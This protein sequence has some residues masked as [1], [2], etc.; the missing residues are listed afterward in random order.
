MYNKCCQSGWGGEWLGDGKSACK[1]TCYTGKHF[2]VNDLPVKSI[3]WLYK[4]YTGKKKSLRDRQI[5]TEKSV[6]KCTCYTGKHFPG[7]DPP[8]ETRPQ[9][10][11]HIYGQKNAYVAGRYFARKTSISACKCTCY[12]GKHIPG[13]YLPVKNMSPGNTKHIQANIL[14][15]WQ[16]DTLPDIQTN[17]SVLVRL[18]RANNSPEIYLPVN[19]V[20]RLLKAS[21]DTNISY[22]PD[23]QRLCP[24]DRQICLY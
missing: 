8:V 10:I 2:P 20:T 12:T 1:C 21:T 13:K 11:Q 16:A 3:P 4:I 7:T 5:S 9:A 18:L 24:G 15:A 14:P 22:V 19:Y 23:R 6:W 17:L